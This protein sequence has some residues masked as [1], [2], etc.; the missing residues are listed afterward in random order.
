MTPRPAAGSLMEPTSADPLADD[1]GDQAAR[2]RRRPHCLRSAHRGHDGGVPGSSSGSRSWGRTST[3]SPPACPPGCPDDA[4]GCW[5]AG[6]ADTSTG[7]GASPIA[8]LAG[9]SGPLD[10]IAVAMFALP[11]EDFRFAALADDLQRPLDGGVFAPAT[12]SA[13]L[14][15]PGQRRVHHLAEGLAASTCWSRSTAARA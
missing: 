14:D 8:S 5:E 15:A 7:V 10:C 3:R 12:V 4:V 6:L 9:V 13:A 2:A 1:I 11:V